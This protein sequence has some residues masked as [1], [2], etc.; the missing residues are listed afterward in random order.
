MALSW[1]QLPSSRN[2]EPM[3]T[4]TVLRNH[5]KEKDQE[6]G[7]YG[8]NQHKDLLGNSDLQIGSLMFVFEMNKYI[9]IYFFN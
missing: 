7:Y 9:Y 6:K 1:A 5:R 8:R 3:I 4:R 2:W